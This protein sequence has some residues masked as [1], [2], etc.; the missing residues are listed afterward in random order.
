[1]KMCPTRIQFRCCGPVPRG[2]ELRCSSDTAGGN[3]CGLPKSVSYQLHTASVSHTP[4][5]T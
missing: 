5:I 2:I 1:M 4:V 3:L